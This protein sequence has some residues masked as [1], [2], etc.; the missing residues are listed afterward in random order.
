MSVDLLDLLP[1]VYPALGSADG[2]DLVFWTTGAL[3]RFAYDAGDSLARRVPFMALRTTLSVVAG[4][5]EY[6]LPARHVGTI[7]V[8]VAGYSL[9]PTSVEELD[10]LDDD[11]RTYEDYSE[12]YIEGLGGEKKVRLHPKPIVTATGHIA[13]TEHPSDDS[14]T[15]A[16]PHALKEYFRLAII[17]GARGS[18]DKGSM[19]EVAAWCTRV[20]GL[21]EQVAAGYWS[22]A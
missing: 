19:P 10:A 3:S 7:H 4:T 14:T 5:A 21:M 2:S 13:Y 6:S 20:M 22:A 16:V 15:L 9:R 18:G 8:S 17:A 11:W 12:R 1:E